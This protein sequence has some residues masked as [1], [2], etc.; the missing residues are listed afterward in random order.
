MAE[1][2]LE[3]LSEEIPA[4]M[5]ARAATQLA[6]AVETALD[7]AEISHGDLASYSTPRRLVLVVRDLATRQPDVEVERKGPRVGA[8]D[9]ALQ[10][11]LG[12]LGV[13]D[14]RLEE[15]D[16]KKGKV[17]IARFTRRGQPTSEVLV[18]LLGQILSR[19][20]WPKSMR[21]GDHPVRWVRPLHS[22]ICLL[23]GSVVP[24]SF[25]P[26]EAGATTQGHR[27]LAPGTMQVTGFEDYRKK[28][29]LAHVEIDAGERERL[30]VDEAERLADEHQLKV[31]SDPGL[32]GEVAGL[33]EWPVPLLG[34]IEQR[35]MALPQEV[36][37][38]SMRQHQKYLALEDGEGRLAPR[39]VIVANLLGRDGRAIIAGNER[40]LRA[41]LWDAQFFWDQDRKSTLASRVPGLDGMVFH[42]RLGSL[43]D[44]VRRLEALAPALAE[45]VAGAA[46]DEAR[47]AARLCKADLVSEMVGEFPELQGIMGRYYAQDAGEPDSIATAIAEHYAPQGPGDQCPG[48]PVSVVVA[49]ADKLDSLAGFFA[50]DEKPTGSKDPFALRRAALGVLRLVLENRLRLPLRAAFEQALAGYGQQI[51]DVDRGAVVSEL[52]DFLADRLKVHLRSEGVRH[53]LIS[54]VFAAGQDDDLIR[55]LARVDALRDFL[56]TDDGANLL[57]AHRRASNIVRIEEKRDGRAFEGA[58]NR[59]RLKQDEEQR[60]FADLTQVGGQIEGALG[61]EAFTEAM[62]ALAHLRRPV[63]AFFD[64]V[65]VNS[66]D[67][68]LRENRLRLLAQIRSALGAVADFSLIEDTET[69]ERR[70]A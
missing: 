1:L 52:L 13:E 12:S 20:S 37:V 15:R 64:R 70:V 46:A 33:V 16:D 62:T 53:D 22:I 44:K 4:R 63:D 45:H 2:L 40:V 32:L 5:Q 6:E 47:H 9:Q 59:D 34:Q 58:P 14:Y 49:L 61:R 36:L 26:V 38:T 39:F 17:H 29:K 41:R 50:I 67:A 48:A 11:F 66:D 18:P 23:D 51:P 68:S 8:P 60:L 43:G 42:A 69:Q 10:G 55:L 65:T 28:L 57:V 27:F 19:F 56:A 54:A 25:G 30:I 3:L 7:R 31:R 21:W 24:L 35:F